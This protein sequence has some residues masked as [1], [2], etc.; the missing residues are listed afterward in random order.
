M[1]MPPILQSCE[2]CGVCCTVVGR[3]PFVVR[4][5]GTGEEHWEKLRDE[6]PDLL[7]ALN[8]QARAE[9]ERGEPTFGVACSWYDPIMR[10]CRHHELR[11]RA[12]RDFEIGGIDCLDARRRAGIDPPRRRESR[13]GPTGVE[14]GAGDVS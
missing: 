14:D 7:D 10:N 13:S 5:D 12:C 4:L 11:P 2:G 1:V 8:R 3:P 6:R 9:R